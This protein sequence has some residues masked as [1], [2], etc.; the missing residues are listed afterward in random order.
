MSSML[1]QSLED[2]GGHNIMTFSL[3]THDRYDFPFHKAQ[4]LFSFSL[5]E[6]RRQ[7]HQTT[8]A[9]RLALH[10]HLERHLASL[11]HRAL[12]GRARADLARRALLLKQLAG[13]AH[14]QTDKLALRRAAAGA[15]AT[16]EHLHGLHGCCVAH[17]GCVG[18]SA[19]VLAAKVFLVVCDGLCKLLLCKLVARC[20]CRCVYRWGRRTLLINLLVRQLAL[21]AHEVAQDT[22]EEVGTARA[23]GVARGVLGSTL[24]EVL[25]VGVVVGDAVL[26]CNGGKVVSE[27]YFLVS[28][29]KGRKEAE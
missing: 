20:L 1:S 19:I 6:L 29:W 22:G 28:G 8:R 4:P 3:P 10:V 23:A 24:V 25:L 18:L 15:A 21:V 9:L 12:L 17:A 27:V 2:N 13:L 7:S 14:R 26:H 16:R 11:L 5:Q